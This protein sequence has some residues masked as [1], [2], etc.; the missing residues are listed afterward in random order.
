MG[1]IR[2]LIISTAS[3]SSSIYGHPLS[4]YS[5][6]NE[7]EPDIDYGSLEF[8]EKMAVIMFLVLLGGCFAGN[9]Q[10]IVAIA[11]NF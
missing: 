8:Y 10:L 1:S 7:E 9:V 2:T 4:A 11:T 6:T 5:E 3:L